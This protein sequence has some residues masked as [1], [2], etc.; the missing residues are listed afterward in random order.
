L[1]VLADVIGRSL[2]DASAALGTFAERFLAREVELHGRL[3]RLAVFGGG[4]LGSRRTRLELETNLAVLA[5]RQER[6]ECAPVFLR[7]KL[8]QQIGLAGREQL[9]HLC[10]LDGLLQN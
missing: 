8:C 3:L 5:D 7:D 4:A 1:R 10:A 9:D 6:L 2:E